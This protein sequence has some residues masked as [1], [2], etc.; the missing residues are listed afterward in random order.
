MSEYN[1]APMYLFTLSGDTDNDSIVFVSDLMSAYLILRSL[2]K[3]KDE[4]IAGILKPFL[5]DN[6]PQ[7]FYF[8][9][10]LKSSFIRYSNTYMIKN[11]SI[12]VFED[13][14]F[15]PEISVMLN[16]DEPKTLYFHCESS[17]LPELINGLTDSKEFA[18]F[19]D[20]LFEHDSLGDYALVEETKTISKEDFPDLAKLNIFWPLSKNSN[21]SNILN[22]TFSPDYNNTFDLSQNDFTDFLESSIALFEEENNEDGHSFYNRLE[23]RKLLKEPEL[24]FKVS[25]L[26][27]N[28]RHVFSYSGDIRSIFAISLG[29]IDNLE[30][31]S[32]I[33]LKALKSSGNR[34]S[35]FNVSDDNIY[36]HKTKICSIEIKIEP[37]PIITVIKQTINTSDHQELTC[38]FSENNLKA[39]LKG[40]FDNAELEKRIIAKTNNLPLDSITALSQ[41][42]IKKYDDLSL[43]SV[44]LKSEEIDITEI[45]FE[46]HKYNA[47]LK[48]FISVKKTG[49]TIQKN[50]VITQDISQLSPL[51]Q[52]YKEIGDIRN[53]NNIDR[54]KILKITFI[55]EAGKLFSFF[56]DLKSLLPCVLGLTKNKELA[57]F[58]LCKAI[59]PELKDNSEFWLPDNL[60]TIRLARI[61]AN[62]FLSRIKVNLEA[63]EEI[64]EVKMTNITAKFHVYKFSKSVAYEFAEGLFSQ[65]TV[66]DIFSKFL[67]VPGKTYSTNSLKIPELSSTNIMNT[68]TGNLLDFHPNTLT[69]RNLDGN[70]VSAKPVKANGKKLSSS[71][72]IVYG[73]SSCAVSNTHKTNKV[74]I[75]VPVWTSNKKV[76]HY[77]TDASFCPSCKCYY[78]DSTNYYGLTRKG[79]ICCRNAT[80]SYYL[81]NKDKD[82]FRNFNPE[83]VIHQYGYNVNQQDDLS[84]RTRQEIL[85]MVVRA[86]IW[87]KQKVISFLEGRIRLAN[88]NRKHMASAISRWEEDISFV[89]HHL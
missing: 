3:D 70:R 80:R 72:L 45:T 44:Y 12:S 76:E 57:A 65:Q 13:E 39:F 42:Q 62:S 82:G 75:A 89:R 30:V 59:N 73:S 53:N 40:F 77:D 64:L 15:I 48:T 8:P 19:C 87:T 34:N 25:L 41:T 68:F 7:T 24:L 55:S 61:N 43:L 18:S 36:L 38:Y 29:A 49:E 37:Q 32:R 31:A 14:P 27:E 84:S 69:I 16:N 50:K 2:F 74:P 28:K 81:E 66:I 5:S 56:S 51:K 52:Y 6:N 85:T 83:S 35:R 10:G 46:K 88:N 47:S 86:N 26:A 78:M 58:I 22:I 1:L 17:V 79:I 20:N 23:K 33:A 4:I 21:E 71:E 11:I 67:P 60:N 9:E 54:H 63:P